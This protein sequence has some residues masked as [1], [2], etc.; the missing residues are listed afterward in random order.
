MFKTCKK[1]KSN[2]FI[3]NN[4]NNNNYKKQ[5]CYKKYNHFYSLNRI[6]LYLI[7]INF[8]PRN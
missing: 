7:I 5:K 3:I 6:L 1:K 4:K 2:L 8:L